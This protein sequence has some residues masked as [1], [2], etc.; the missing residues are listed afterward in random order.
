MCA[1]AVSGVAA[2]AA[3][4]GAHAKWLHRD[5]GGRGAPHVWGMMTSSDIER[6]AW[7]D[8]LAHEMFQTE[9]SAVD[10]PRVEAERLGDT[11]PARVLRAVADHAKTAL[12]ELTPLMRRS[13]LVVSRGGKAVGAA[14]SRIRDHFAD[15]LLSREKSYRATLLGMRHGV[16]LVELVATLARSDGDLELAEWCEGWLVVRRPLVEDAARA[17]AWFAEHPERAT[18]AARSD[19]PLA[20]GLHTLMRRYQH[21]TRRLRETPAKAHAAAR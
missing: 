8:L 5:G 4:A 17:L 16:D 10:H 2:A 19:N 13:D 14:F 1:R 12:A 11:P 6:R 20:L 21:V 18:E 3:G 15:L 7:L 9:Q